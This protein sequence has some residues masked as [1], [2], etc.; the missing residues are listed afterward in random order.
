MLPSRRVPALCK[1]QQGMEVQRTAHGKEEVAGEES[2]IYHLFANREYRASKQ[3]GRALPLRSQEVLAIRDA[4]PL[5]RVGAG[6][7]R[8]K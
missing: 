6:A 8:R 3:R 7:K 4:A 5:K 1:C 2:K